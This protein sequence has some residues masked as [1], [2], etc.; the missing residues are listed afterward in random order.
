MGRF[1]SSCLGNDPFV[2]LKWFDYS[3][4][5]CRIRVPTNVPQVA[6]DVNM[7]QRLFHLT[8]IDTKCPYFGFYRYLKI[9]MFFNGRLHYEMKVFG[10]GKVPGR[11]AIFVHYKPHFQYKIGS[12]WPLPKIRNPFEIFLWILG[13]PG[14][15]MG[16]NTHFPQH[17]QQI[18]R[19]FEG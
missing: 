19:H 6:M 7:N 5:M 4:H 3:L 9:C 11:F 8:K 18:S 17:T 12:F 2:S 13:S 10:L 14:L 16:Q 1:F 15:Y